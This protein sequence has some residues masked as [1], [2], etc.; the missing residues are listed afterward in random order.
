VI[1]VYGEVMGDRHV[2]SF[3]PGGAVGGFDHRVFTLSVTAGDPW[4]NTLVALHEAA[5]QGL[6]DSTAWGHLLQTFAILPDG[7]ST[8][9]GLS[10][11][12][13]QTHEAYATLTSVTGLLGTRDA[14]PLSEIVDAYPAY[15]SYLGGPAETG[16]HRVAMATALQVCM[17]SDVLDVTPAGSVAAALSERHSPDARRALLLRRRDR[18]FAEVERRAAG[19]LGDGWA[20]TSGVASVGRDTAADMLAALGQASVD[21]AQVR[22]ARRALVTAVAE[23]VGPIEIDENV[24]NLFDTEHLQLRS[25][26]R[27]SVRPAGAVPPAGADRLLAVRTAAAVR[28]QFALRDDPWPVTGDSPV[29][30][31]R[32][33]RG[34]DVDL[35]PVAE[36]GQVSAWRLEVQPLLISIALGCAL[37]RR[38]AR[39]WSAAFTEADV[40]TIL[41]DKPLGQFVDALLDGPER[42]RHTLMP[43]GDNKALLALS[44][45]GLPPYLRIC[46]LAAAT[47]AR[48]RLARDPRAVDVE[49]P[50]AFSP[51]HREL[52]MIGRRIVED[53][54]TV[55]LVR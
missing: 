2:L 1:G 30:V 32:A 4:R 29:A 13:A 55:E 16:W 19:D 3:A 26:R 54:S 21:A 46:S 28:R 17:Q 42:L 48:I 5:H 8:L 38:W 51:R 27:A 50:A 47:G 40:V 20:A 41:I 12:C 10:Q 24:T 53:E 14:P 37:D 25:P 33:R 18:F 52:A 39:D 45:P 43:C 6:N 7:G 36:P 35:Y 31:I 23:V 44:L 49:D 34:E 9:K 15:R 11:R 22:A